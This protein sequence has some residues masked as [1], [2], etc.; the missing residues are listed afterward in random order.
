MFPA[1]AVLCIA[2]LE[3]PEQ[4]VMVKWIFTFLNQMKLVED[5]HS[6]VEGYLRLY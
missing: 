1:V 4:I 5:T 6:V 3:R 2:R